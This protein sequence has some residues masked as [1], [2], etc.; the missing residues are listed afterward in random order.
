MKL[1]KLAVVSLLLAVPLAAQQPDT[2]VKM[3]HDAMGMGMGQGMGRGHDMM[4]AMA[5]MMAPLVGVMAY[6]P[7]PLLDHKDD[8]KLT[9]DQI[10]KL[11]ALQTQARTMHEGLA[12]S[13]KPHFDAMNAAFAKGDAAGAKM[14]LNAAHDAMGKAHAS[15]IDIASQAR[16]ALTEAQRAQVDGWA[17]E[18]QGKMM[19]GGEH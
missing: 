6:M 9:P 8:L 19:M 2:T 5:S 7:G 3:K 14:H 15:S 1:S 18:M 17:K 13:V 10:T 4:E 12:A 11:T 16:A